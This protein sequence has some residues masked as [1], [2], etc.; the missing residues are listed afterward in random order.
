[1]TQVAYIFLITIT[2]PLAFYL[3]KVIGKTYKNSKIIGIIVSSGWLFWTFLVT[4]PAVIFAPQLALILI[5]ILVCFVIIKMKERKENIETESIELKNKHQ[6]AVD[7][8]DEYKDKYNKVL[9][10]KHDLEQG[11]RDIKKR[12][13]IRPIIDIFKML[14]KR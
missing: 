3:G 14:R 13:L 12:G 11:T 9:K 4:I 8:R 6:Y 10:E 7:E 2:I 1:M 5:L